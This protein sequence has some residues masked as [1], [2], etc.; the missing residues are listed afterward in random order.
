M[1]ADATESFRF[2]GSSEIGSRLELA[3]RIATAAGKLTLKHFRNE[4][5]KVI[6]QRRWFSTDG[7]RS[8]SRDVFASGD[9]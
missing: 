9:R 8:G 6:R 1:T 2:S 3:N 4:D 7:R 5:L